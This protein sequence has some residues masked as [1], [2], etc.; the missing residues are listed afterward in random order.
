MPGDFPMSARVV[1]HHASLGS[2]TCCS[3][4]SKC[5]KSGQVLVQNHFF[6]TICQKSFYS[7]FVTLF[8][9]L[10]LLYMSPSPNPLCTP[11]PSPTPLPSV[12]CV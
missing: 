5:N 6:K 12:V 4:S 3:Q 7:V 2:L 9:L 11:L 8:L 1:L 10:T